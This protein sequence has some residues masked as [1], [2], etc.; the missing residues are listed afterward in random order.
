M[1]ADFIAVKEVSTQNSR[2]PKNC[3]PKPAE[4]AKPIS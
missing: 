4:K 1:Q 3:Q 2:E